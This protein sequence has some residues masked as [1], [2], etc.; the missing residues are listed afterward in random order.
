VS[1]DD[2]SWT[3]EGTSDGVLTVDVGER[4]LDRA[5]WRRISGC[6]P[7]RTIGKTLAR[8]AGWLD[9]YGI[10]VEVVQ[11]S[12]VLLRLGAGVKSPWWLKP[13]GVRRLRPSWRGLLAAARL[14]GA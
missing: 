5:T 8:T 13:L 9:R 14:G 11:A 12:H 3:I 6:T 4:P 1:A 10:Q 2:V 7:R